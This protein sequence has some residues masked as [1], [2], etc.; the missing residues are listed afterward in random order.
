MFAD[1]SPFSSGSRSLASLL[2]RGFSM[3]ISGYRAAQL[4]KSRV[5]MPTEKII[6]CNFCFW[7]CACGELVN[8]HMKN[9]GNREKSFFY[10]QI[11]FIISVKKF[12]FRWWFLLSRIDIR[13]FLWWTFFRYVR[14][15]Y[16][17]RDR[18]NLNNVMTSK[19]CS[20]WENSRSASV[21][22]KKRSVPAFLWEAYSLCVG[23]I[24]AAGSFV[25]SA[26]CKFTYVCIGRCMNIS[27]SLK[28]RLYSIY[29]P[30]W[31]LSRYIS[32]NTVLSSYK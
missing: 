15:L 13:W 22:R 19:A 9:G 6:F 4:S 12:Q 21:A 1:Y 25:N 7:G 18:A 8:F 28:S 10:K 20:G 32:M 29:T 31:Y 5:R 2:R 3:K 24:A 16:R 30:F 11:D 26:M 23:P 17:A 14:N 27:R